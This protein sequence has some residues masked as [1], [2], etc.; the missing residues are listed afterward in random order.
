M[1]ERNGK[2]VLVIRDGPHD[3]VF[4]DV[5]QLGPVGFLSRLA[6]PDQNGKRFRP[7][8]SGKVS[9]VTPATR[10]IVDPLWFLTRL[11]PG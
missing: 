7:A 2:R 11:F 9:S 1:G 6:P 3:Y 10:N 8:P 4:T 5:G